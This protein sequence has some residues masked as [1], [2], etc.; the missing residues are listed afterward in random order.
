MR[1]RVPQS[2]PAA[3][4]QRP[5][6]DYPKQQKQTA[7]T[8]GYAGAYFVIGC[9]LFGRRDEGLGD[10]D[11]VVGSGDGVRV[12]LEETGTLLVGIERRGNGIS[13]G[14]ADGKIQ[15]GRGS[16][17][18]QAATRSGSVSECLSLRAP[19]RRARPSS[20]I[21]SSLRFSQCQQIFKMIHY[22]RSPNRRGRHG[23]LS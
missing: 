13:G 1:G 9:L 11:D 8:V 14:H 18:L 21:A 10:R 17:G 5:T 4:R 2:L 15:V 7:E 3:M 22:P 12:P 19:P 16:S 6:V 23:S 20:W